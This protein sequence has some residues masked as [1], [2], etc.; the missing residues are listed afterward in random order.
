M[1]IGRWQIEF[2]CFTEDAVGLHPNITVRNLG[3][4]STTQQQQQH[5]FVELTGWWW[6]SYLFSCHSGLCGH[7]CLY[8]DLD[9]VITGSLVGLLDRAFASSSSTTSAN[10]SST[11]TTTSTT[12]TSSTTTISSNNNGR[13]CCY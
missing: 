1:S 5:P 11:T 2:I 4:F 6:K 7:F 13:C 9:V 8:F 12:T 10:S 3:Y